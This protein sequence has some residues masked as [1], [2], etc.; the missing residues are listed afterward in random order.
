M[1]LKSTVLRV[2]ACACFGVAFNEAAAR[3][4]DKDF[5]VFLASDETVARFGPLPLE[6]ALIAKAIDQAA[7]LGARGLILKLFLDQKRSAEGDLALAAS[8]G[9]LPVLLQA[10][11]DE[12][13]V[14]PNPFEERFGL[15]DK[16]LQSSS[17]GSRGW[18]P[19]PEF[20]NA[21]HS[22]CFVDFSGFP[23]PLV[24]QYGGLPVKSLI[25]CAIEMA[26]GEAVKIRNGHSFHFGAKSLSVDGMNQYVHRGRFSEARDVLELAN[27]IEGKVSAA[28]VKGRIVLIGYD[29]SDMATVDTPSR[30]MGPHR[31]FVAYLK[32]IFEDLQ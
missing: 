5:A 16:S 1:L 26:T 21:A 10:R 13:E 14:A 8:M 19:I 29:T 11:M 6:R 24:E 18:I 22:V 17:T 4:F 12:S 9:R 3:E 23:V 28:Q 32:T 30:P 25:V 31:A 7:R 2:A 20:P 27:L 15:A